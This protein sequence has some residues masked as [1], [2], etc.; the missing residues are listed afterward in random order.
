MTR[1]PVTGFNPMPHPDL[2]G[3]CPQA[4]IS[5]GITAENVAVKYRIP[6]ERQEAFAVDSQAKATA[7]QAAGKFDEEIVPITH[8]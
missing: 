8:E 7:A 5:M 6:R 2:Y 3:K 4:Y 1:V